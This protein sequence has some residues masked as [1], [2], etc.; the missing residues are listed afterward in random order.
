[1]FRFVSQHHVK[2]STPTTF[3]L[4]MAG[5]WSTCLAAVPQQLKVQET[6]ALATYIECGKIWHKKVPTKPP[7][8]LDNS[9]FISVA[10]IIDIHVGGK[11]HP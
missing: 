8:L 2:M 7:F 11:D 1:M 6:S 5:R 10:R 3:W 9:T 4:T